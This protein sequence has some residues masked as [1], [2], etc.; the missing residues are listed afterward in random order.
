MCQVKQ[1]FGEKRVALQAR[2]QTLRHILT[3]IGTWSLQNETHIH[4]R[5]HYAATILNTFDFVNQDIQK[6]LLLHA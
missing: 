6:M 2:L 1:E 4:I 3:Q 5:A